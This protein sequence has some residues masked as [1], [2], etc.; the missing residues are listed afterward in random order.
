MSRQLARQLRLAAPRVQVR[1]VSNVAPTQIPATAVP[2]PTPSPSSVPP[3]NASAG[4]SAGPSSAPR[5]T[6]FGFQEVPEEEKESLG[7]CLSPV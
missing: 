7:E 1:A 2:S 6:H 5:K 3:V 4:P